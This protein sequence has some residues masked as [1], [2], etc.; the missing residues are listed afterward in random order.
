M[1]KNTIRI[2]LSI[3]ITMFTVMTICGCVSSLI[4][5]YPIKC[6]WCGTEIKQHYSVVGV[7]L[8]SKYEVYRGTPASGTYLGVV[9]IERDALDII[10]N[11]K[12]P[13]VIYEHGYAFCKL[14]CL[15]AYEGS[16]DIKEKR[17]R[18]IEGE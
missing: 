12:R 17:I 9:D 6:A 2:C 8:P 18:I 4:G 1:R 13:G 16:K 11:D 3:S 14:K 7:G 5:D 15:N 10:N